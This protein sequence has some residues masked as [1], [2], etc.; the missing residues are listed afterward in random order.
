DW[1]AAD[2]ILEGS[3][4][5]AR[6]EQFARALAP[7]DAVISQSASVNKVASTGRLSSAES[8]I[9]SM[10]SAPTQVR[11]VASMT[12]LPDQDTRIAVCSLISLGLLRK[13]TG[14]EEITPEQSEADENL[15][16]LQ[17]E[18]TRKIH[19]FA[20][21]DYY[22]VLGVTRRST[23]AEIK[24]AYYALA[25]KFHPDRFRQP[26]YVDLRLKLEAVFAK[27]TQAYETLGDRVHKAMYDDKLKKS[28]N[29]SEPIV[30]RPRAEALSS[31]PVETR[32]A[33][34]KPVDSRPV[35]P[36]PVEKRSV[37]KPLKSGK[38]G[39]LGP[40]QQPGAQP[41]IAQ[42]SP[43]TNPQPPI[44]QPTPPVQQAAQPAQPV[45]QSASHQAAAAAPGQAENYYK[46]GRARIDNRDYY[47]AVQL[48]RE[49]VRLD[50]QKP[51]YHYHLGM[52]L[53]RNP[54]TRREGELHLVKAAALDPFNAQIRVRLGL[55]YKEGGL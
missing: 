25:K 16:Q 41:A 54:R 36:P 27:M 33:E 48:L 3:R 12:G 30:E 34:P 17:A 4:H 47:G 13:G 22:E 51:H 15:A 44:E 23:P 2:C 18:I 46:Q 40:G 55:V 7:D 20:N 19:F 35:E 37:S 1:T 38:T 31:R 50:S 10:V 45:D 53:L 11:D 24:A 21:A 43:K 6:I 8:Y 29:H 26:E 14:P 5:A 39:A 49:A 9:L 42:E 28:P 32:R 52:A